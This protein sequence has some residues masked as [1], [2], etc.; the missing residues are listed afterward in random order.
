MLIERFYCEYCDCYC[1]GQGVYENHIKGKRHKSNMKKAQIKEAPSTTMVKEEKS[2]KRPRSPDKEEL[3]VVKKPKIE[4][5]N[6]DKLSN[7]PIID[8]QD[9][10]DKKLIDIYSK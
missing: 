4:K 7:I 2:L 10:I 6:I 5:D 9:V 3:V 8:I 1:N